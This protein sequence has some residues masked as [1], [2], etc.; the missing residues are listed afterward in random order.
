MTDLQIS[1]IAIG[2]TIVVGVIS[3][4]KWQEY[5]A[6]KSIERH[7]SNDHDDV[8]MQPSAAADG[9]SN[10][11][12]EP[13]FSMPADDPAV[14]D[15]AAEAVAADA[16]AAL[17]AQDLPV[18]PLIDCNIPLMLE[19]VVH[20]AQILPALQALTHIGS[21]PIHFI[22]L[23]QNQVWEAVRNGG[24][25]SALQAGVQLANRSSALTELEYSELVTRLRAV[26]DQLGAEPDV[27]DM[28]EVVDIARELHRFIAEHDAQLGINIHTNGAPWALNSLHTMLEKQG[29]EL[30]ADGRLGMPDGDGG[31]LFLLSTNA[32][33]GAATTARLTLLLEVP[34]VAPLRDGFGAMTAC[35]K[36]LAAKLGGSVVDDGSQILSDEA[37]ADI[38]AQVAAFYDDMEA[39]EIPAGSNRAQRLFQ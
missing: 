3:Y 10:A 13:G 23:N 21:K 11:R 6:R 1:L 27:P 38:A 24:I 14:T 36:L 5:R 19:G 17:P 15:Q 7:F 2:G 37:L 20:G 18:D 22:G 4:N 12:H 30:R 29:F 32:T 35:A 8:L 16:Q 25:Y 9:A 28:A 39:A 33:P 26:A 31:N 34:C